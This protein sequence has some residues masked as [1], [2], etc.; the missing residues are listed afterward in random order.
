MRLNMIAERA[1]N[2]LNAAQQQQSAAE[3]AEQKRIQKNLAALDIKA[4]TNVKAASKPAVGMAN[5]MMGAPQ[6]KPAARATSNKKPVLLNQAAVAWGAK[7]KPA[8]FVNPFNR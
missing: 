5:R 2:K 4:Q 6:K 3:A 8:A 1:L 7:K